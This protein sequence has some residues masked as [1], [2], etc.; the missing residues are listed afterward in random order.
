M[1]PPDFDFFP[2]LKHYYDTE[3]LELE[4]ARQVRRMN[5]GCLA[6]ALETCHRDGNQS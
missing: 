1:S 5:S 2:K 3:D 6:M 4:V